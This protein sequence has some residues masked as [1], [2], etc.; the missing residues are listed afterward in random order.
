[1]SGKTY[2]LFS[3]IC[4]PAHMT[5]AEKYLLFLI[6]ELLPYRRIILVVP[7]DGLLA[8]EARKLGCEVQVHPY[9]LVWPLW[10]PGPDLPALEEHWGRS[11]ELTM[12]MNLL[13]MHR[14][15]A[16]IALTCVNAL[17]AMAASRLGIPVL[18]MITEVMRAGPFAPYAVS[19]IHRYS[20]WIGGISEATLSIFLSSGL[21][22]KTL[23][24]EPSWHPEQ[25]RPQSWSD[26][27][28]QLRAAY[29]IGPKVT[30][31]GYIVS[32]I[33]P[34]K[35]FDHFVEMAVRLCPS[36]PQAHFLIIGQ[37]TD[38]TYYDRT[39]QIVHESGYASRFILI[40][41]Q[42]SI[43]SVYPAMDDRA[44]PDT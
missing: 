29:G 5:G 25:F 18:W 27:R 16:V 23:M 15:N 33:T 14:P 21:G 24:L 4:N 3:H 22:A 7:G 37:P 40:P 43:E 2:M 39:V 26:H 13:H 36:H 6:R 20:T 8:L 42:Q 10:E 17:P 19:V 38:R 41:Y 11:Q 12:L 35:G 30:L 31:I 9:P 28:K 34:H 32:D 44:E 1:M